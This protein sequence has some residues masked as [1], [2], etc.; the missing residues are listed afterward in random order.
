MIF[1]LEVVITV[2]VHAR[3]PISTWGRK[4]PSDFHQGRKLVTYH[5]IERRKSTG[6][7]SGR[8]RLFNSSLFLLI[9]GLKRSPPHKIT[10]KC[11][12]SQI[13]FP[14][15]PRHVPCNLSG[16]AR[17]SQGEKVV[18][19]HGVKGEL[20]QT[21]ECIQLQT[22]WIQPWAHLSCVCIL[23]LCRTWAKVS[24]KQID[25][26]TYTSHQLWI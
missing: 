18:E 25:S 15:P 20:F 11:T 26:V 5:V 23:M 13:L 4:L 1:V 7:G 22:A 17:V 10:L 6:R 9:L 14:F 3:A 19:A 21:I 12:K 2:L 16:T 24:A 8:E